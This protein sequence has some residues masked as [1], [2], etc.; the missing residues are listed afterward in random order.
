MYV[1]IYI[2]ILYVTRM[3]QNKID[4][5]NLI[6]QHG[7]AADKNYWVVFLTSGLPYYL[8]S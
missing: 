7:G 5:I 1:Q 8:L 4:S 2:P 6:L 3:T